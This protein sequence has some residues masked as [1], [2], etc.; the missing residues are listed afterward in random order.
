MFTWLRIDTHDGMERLGL[1]EIQ[2]YWV[3]TGWWHFAHQ[4]PQAYRGEVRDYFLM[5]VWGSSR[6]FMTVPFQ[7][8][9]LEN[10][11]AGEI[12]SDIKMCK[13]A[14]LEH[15]AKTNLLTKPVGQKGWQN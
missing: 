4:F 15:R 14:R 12:S 10:S 3:V 1:Y 2:L 9:W 8:H 7:F 11:A 13:Y 5:V 6:G